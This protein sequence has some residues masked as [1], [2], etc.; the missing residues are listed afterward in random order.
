MDQMDDRWQPR[1]WDK[2]PGFAM[3][4]IDPDEVPALTRI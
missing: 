3:W 1:I 4:M 2:N